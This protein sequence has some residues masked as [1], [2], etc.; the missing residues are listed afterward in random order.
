MP[1][2]LPTAE[3]VLQVFEVFARESRPLS[4]SEMARMLGIADSSCSDL[5]FTLRQAGY[6]LRTP[7]TRLFHPTARLLDV[8]KG[9]AAADPMQIFES[10]TLDLLSRESGE[11][12]LCGHLEG[13][14]V[15]IF[16]CHESPKALRYVLKP[17]ALFDLN[18]SALGKALL[19]AMEPPARD[20]LIDV[21]PMRA[22]TD[23]S[24]V[25]KNELRRQVAQCGAEGVYHAIDEGSEGV[26]AMGVAGIIGG[27]LT[28][29]SLV[30]P[31]SR[32]ERHRDKNAGILLRAREEFFE[33]LG[34]SRNE[35]S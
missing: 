1:Q 19:G 20:A 32:I 29:I 12:S 27:R 15:K 22:V 7:Q 25:D 3:R 13:H 11:S 33:P 17:G 35:L 4:N 28:A 6:L 14:C 9:I 23:K 34:Q 26:S 16:A 21:L 8:A 5:L 30:G 18:V 31:T 10:E 24:I 2:I